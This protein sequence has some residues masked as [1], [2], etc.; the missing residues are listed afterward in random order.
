MIL[1][2]SNEVFIA[3]LSDALCGIHH[4]KNYYLESVFMTLLTLKL[5]FN[6]TINHCL[7]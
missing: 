7:I 3:V 4:K 6:V 2:D 1:N 5:V